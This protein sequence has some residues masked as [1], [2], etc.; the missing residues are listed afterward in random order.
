[1]SFRGQRP[2]LGKNHLNIPINQ[3]GFRQVIQIEKKQSYFEFTAATRRKKKVL[4]RAHARTLVNPIPL[5]IWSYNYF[6]FLRS[7]DLLLLFLKQ[8]EEH[9]LK[10]SHFPI[11]FCFTLL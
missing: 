7:F 10:N 11:C 6:K 3:A 8:E 1:M 5:L 2:H 9:Q 4:L